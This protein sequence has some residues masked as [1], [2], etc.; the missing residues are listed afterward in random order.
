MGMSVSGQSPVTPSAIQSTSDGA[1]KFDVRLEAPDRQDQRPETTAAPTHAAFRRTATRSTAF[2]P[3]SEP[4]QQ[5]RYD[6]EHGVPLV[7]SRLRRYVAL[8]LPPAA[9][10]R[11]RGDGPDQADERRTGERYEL[12]GE[13]RSS[14][15]PPASEARRTS[16]AT[17]QARGRR[18]GRDRPA[19]GDDHTHELERSTFPSTTP[20]TPSA[21]SG[22][23]ARTVGPTIARAPGPRR[24][25]AR[26]RAPGRVW[27]RRHPHGDRGPRGR[28][29][30]NTYTPTRMIEERLRATRERH[31]TDREKLIPP[32]RPAECSRTRCPGAR[33]RT[34]G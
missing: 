7:E 18:T 30:A 23:P 9:S 16:V 31:R 3:E 2:E 1:W 21:A 4:D 25:R 27:R 10:M 13:T 11:K 32:R 28:G 24:C 8:P 22:F 15:P 14:P 29:P 33:V 17:N 19:L 5:K 26:W 12:V 34:R 20:Y 6:G